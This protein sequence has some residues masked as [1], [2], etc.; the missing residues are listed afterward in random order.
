MTDTWYDHIYREHNT[1]A[2]AIADRG[3]AYDERIDLR[4]PTCA[5]T[6]SI[7]ALLGYFDGA[8]GKDDN[9]HGGAGWVLYVQ[10]GLE[11]NSK[12]HKVAAGWHPTPLHDPLEAELQAMEAITVAA[13]QT[14]TRGL[15]G[16]TETPAHQPRRPRLH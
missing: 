12:W 6:H 14:A 3:T 7:A 5:H 11:S 8:G 4:L 13:V 15:L 9:P 16:I 1:E 2:D 10:Y